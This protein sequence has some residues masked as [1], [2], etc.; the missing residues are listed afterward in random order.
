MTDFEKKGPHLAVVPR[1]SSTIPPE[2]RGRTSG[3]FRFDLTKTLRQNP[4]YEGFRRL[5]HSREELMRWTT[6][7]VLLK[8]FDTWDLLP[9]EIRES[10]AE[11][12]NI[13]MRFIADGVRDP[14]NPGEK[15]LPSPEAIMVE[16]ARVLLG[17]ID[18]WNE[19]EPSIQMTIEHEMIEFIGQ[20]H[21]EMDITGTREQADTRAQ[22]IRKLESNHNIANRPADHAIRVEE[23][24][25]RV[26]AKIVARL[27]SVLCELELEGGPVPSYSGEREEIR[28]TTYIDIEELE[29]GIRATTRTAVARA[30]ALPPPA[31]EKRDT[32]PASPIAKRN[33]GKAKPK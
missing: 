25:Q 27:T 16:L 13:L 24:R 12:R 19:L 5:K 20:H 17:T 11:E 9:P 30:A 1:Y 2:R 33:S 6:T 18:E 31:T 14:Q 28:D 29:K 7:A 10:E 22:F 3:K 26:M 8:S 4:T 32:I 15:K 21:E 23:A